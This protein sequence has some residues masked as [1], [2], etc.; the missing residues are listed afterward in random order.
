MREEI[1]ESKRRKVEMWSLAPLGLLFIV[2]NWILFRF[3][4][5]SADLPVSYALFFFGLVNLN[6][7]VF[8]G[9]IFF[10]G[11]NLVKIYAD[12]KPRMIGRTLKTRLFL[13]FISFAFIPTTLMFLVSVFYINNSFDRW[14]ANR[15]DQTLKDASALAEQY[16]SEVRASSFYI[17]KSVSEKLNKENADVTA[18]LESSMKTHGV[19]ALE[20]YR[21]SDF[22]KFENIFQDKMGF[23]LPQINWKDVKKYV[24]ANKIRSV[25]RKTEQ[26][27]WL[28]SIVV[29]SEQESILVVSRILP[30]TLLNTIESIAT[31]RAEFQ[32]SKDFKF[33]LKSMYL[34]ILV[35]MTLVILAFGGW[36]SLYLAQSLSRSLFALG[37]ATKR[38]SKGDFHT[39]DFKT[40]MDEIN[41]LVDN[42]NS[43]TNQ[44]KTTRSNLNHSI[45]DL[46]RS[47]IYMNT[48]LA[49]VSS[50]VISCNNEYEITLINKR[51]QNLFD[52]DPE[53]VRGKSL[54]DVLPTE[55][56]DVIESYSGVEDEV[57]AFEIDVVKSRDTVLPLQV[58][59]S[60]LFGINGNQIGYII[61]VEKVELLRENQRVK[62]WKEVATRVAHEIKNPLTPVKLSAERLQ[63]KFGDQIKDPAFKEC[64]ST[65]V[66]QVDLIRD[67]VNE[68]NQFA[69][70]PKLRPSEV[71][72]AAFI[73][74]I[75]SIYKASHSKVEFDVT[76][77]EMSPVI[78]DKDQMKRVFIN[79]IENSIEAMKSVEKKII[80]IK[81]SYSESGNV[82]LIKYYDSGPGVP[83]EKWSDVFKTKYTTKKG[84]DGL[85]L[86]I[87]KKIVE[88]HGGRISILKGEL[89]PS[90]FLIE[91]SV[92]VGIKNPAKV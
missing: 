25:S 72:L 64:T 75:L 23:Y 41:E 77:P 9:I 22:K 19:D 26:G 32:T 68:F 43:M 55:I 78:M 16:V 80:Y 39:I 10:L 27:E 86:S 58:S 24:E 57:Q 50:G 8:L 17:G 69:R 48:L 71:D 79:L 85:G 29:L 61:T 12:S 40:G 53:T 7:L 38:I 44:L 60:S 82:V 91:L 89:S 52:L 83:K 21:L 56:F 11:R 46:N 90:V 66:S 31:S 54:K 62:A 18:V 36:F 88:D 34:F 92:K 65:I 14:F 51:T 4:N 3:Y 37:H 49:Q 73:S 33:P 5:I 81:P 70:F 15:T 6:V 87:V 30:F 47:S 74:E 35:T 67:L 28:S 63:K 42:F 76:V 1:A 13:A 45:D 84:S 20:L 2:L 59:V